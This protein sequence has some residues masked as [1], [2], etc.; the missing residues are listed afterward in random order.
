MKIKYLGTAAAE[1]IPALFCTCETCREARRSGGRNMRSRS[2]A[3]VEDSLLIDFPCDSLYHAWLNGLDFTTL[4]HCVITH[5]HPD[6][7]YPPELCNLRTGFASLP[8]NWP[9]FNIYGSAD[10]KAASAVAFQYAPERICFHPVLP[11]QSFQAGELTVTPLK[12]YHGTAHPYIYMIQNSHKT[13]LY[14]HDTDEFPDET[15][16][17]LKKT[18]PHFDFVSLDCTGGAHQDLPYRAHMCLGRNVSCRNE[19]R[20]WGLIDDRSLVCLNHFSHNGLSVLY[21]DFCGI[22]EKEGF[23]VS[24]DGMELEF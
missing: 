17:F 13:M 16:S 18:R 12:A 21:D 6:H 5:I 9:V 1:G 2:Q 10:L 11:F 14:A 20:R 23:I 24:Y 19:M 22:A 7:F 15:W 4:R 3:L 8:E